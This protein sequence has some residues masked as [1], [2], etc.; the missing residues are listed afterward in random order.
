MAKKLGQPP[1]TA[2]PNPLTSPKHTLRSST[3]SLSGDPTA[4]QAHVKLPSRAGLG[5]SAALSV[6][7]SRA[8]ASFCRPPPSPLAIETAANSAEQVFHGSS[9]GV[10]VALAFHGGIGIFRRDA[11]Y[12]A[13]PDVRPIP[14]AIA[15]SG[16][17]SNTA[18]MVSHVGAARQNNPHVATQLKTLGIY[19]MQGARALQTA[20]LHALGL[21]MN[22][23]HDTLSE[24]GVSTPLLDRLVDVARSTGAIGA[25]LT[26][27]G[28]GGAVIALCPGHEAA[29][30]TAWKQLGTDAFVAK[31]GVRAGENP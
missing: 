28:G 1:N 22:Q 14:I 26:G 19:A 9:S 23:A 10:D 15:V 29:I 20:N 4:V 3:H 6:A 24:L 2:R 5:S 13:M 12:Q 7:L 25:K 18:K 11:G 21:L 8:I 27:A 31:V 17:T 16:Q 30:V